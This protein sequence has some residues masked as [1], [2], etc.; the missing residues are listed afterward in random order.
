MRELGRFVLSCGMGI[1]L[2][3]TIVLSLTPL[4][5]SLADPPILPGKKI[6]PSRDPSPK[7]TSDAFKVQQ[8]N[9]GALCKIVVKAAQER[10]VCELEEKLKGAGLV[11]IADVES[12][13]LV[14]HK[15]DA[16][17]NFMGATIAGGVNKCYLQSEAALKL[18]KANQIL[19]KN[20]PSFRLLVTEGYRPPSVQRRMWELVKGTPMQKYVA[21]PA[22]GS[23][24]NYGVAVDVTITD[25]RGK[26]LDMGVP[27]GHFGLLS[28]PC[29]EERL[30]QQ[31]WLTQQQISAR[32][33]LRNVMTG[34]GFT[35]LDIEYWHFNSC[36]RQTAAGRY[37]IIE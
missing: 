37:K 35:G 28:H 13:I 25:E 17:I 8:H 14:N 36:D 4:D 3:I 29:E 1:M 7:S 22:T 2:P 23:M 21:N 24:H 9:E 27:M 16:G 31:G 33:L 6:A 18:K 15:S 34:S 5:Y 30:L 12:A 10:D 32:E 26:R 19:K 20:R 11:N